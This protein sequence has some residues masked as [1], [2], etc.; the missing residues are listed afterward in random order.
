MLVGSYTQSGNRSDSAAELAVVT[1]VSGTYTVVAD[2]GPINGTG[3]Y[4]LHFLQLPGV[5][6]IPGGDQGGP[7]GNGG[8]HD[9][10][11]T[12]SDLDGWTFDAN[13]GDTVLLKAGQLSGGFSFSPRIRLHGPDGTLIATDAQSGNRSDSVAELVVEV[14]DS[15]THT[16]VVDSGFPN[17]EGDY[18]L[19]FLVLPEAFSVPGADDGGP[20]TVGGVQNGTITTAD[21]DV[22]SFE[23][24]QGNTIVLSMQELTGSSFSPS[25]WLYGPNGQLLASGT[26]ASL[27]QIS[28]TLPNGGL[29][30]VVATGGTPNGTG[31]YEL[32]ATGLPE[33]GKQLRYA[34]LPSDSITV[35]WPS[36]LTDH[37]LQ[38]NPVLQSTGWT[39]V[40]E[41][42]F[43]N[44]LNVRITITIPA[45]GNRFYRLRPPVTP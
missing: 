30:V 13:A 20:L 22:W 14:E 16:A 3:D 44:G 24:N 40:G 12:L 31:T 15:G 32:T 21:L 45:T 41:A 37:V 18:R 28:L 23:A 27:A 36:A 42:P 26:D 7:L 1:A 25:L 6:T 19:H 5:F 33:Q 10:T 9:G 4:R 38:E 35:N 17:G 11:I 8:N 39:D 29:F 34:R 2:S 43:D